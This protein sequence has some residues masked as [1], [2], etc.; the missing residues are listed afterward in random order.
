MKR[1]KLSRSEQMILALLKSSLNGEMPDSSVFID[2]S[3]DD[4]KKC[5]EIAIKQGVLA[6]AWD[7]VK[8]LP[9]NLQP[10]KNLKI[11]WAIAVE[12]YENTYD[13]Y[14]QVVDELFQYFYSQN[15]SMVQLKGVGLSTIYPEQRHREGGDI[16]IYVCPNGCFVE[17]CS[18]QADEALDKLGCGV[19]KDYSPKHS[20]CRYKG[21]PIE[22][23]KTFADLGLFPV[24]DQI[25][26]LLQG[27]LNP[28]KAVL[29]NGGEVLIP[30]PEFNT[31]FVAYHNA[32]HYGSGFSLHHLVDWA[33]IIRKYGLN[34][35]AGLKDAHFINGV[36]A[37]TA[38]CNRFLG[39]DVKIEYTPRLANEML[40]ELFCPVSDRIIPT[41]NIL[42]CYLHRARR[43]VDTT[44]ISNS[45]L[46][47]PLW[48]NP[49]FKSKFIRMIKRNIGK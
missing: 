12:K 36:Y 5:S 3:A 42:K 40:K 39:T 25:E 6:L 20:F 47:L 48:K 7:G 22:N 45:I 1:F 24:S 27:C 28:S 15:M 9:K 32:M 44:R 4:W 37:M 33:C 23:H 31:L 38:L 34:L 49:R 29:P 16:D 46:Y 21:I 17:N 14:C 10:Y 26:T 35:P 30:S 13:F 43:F 18:R 2:A 11:S 19:K 8:L 41:D